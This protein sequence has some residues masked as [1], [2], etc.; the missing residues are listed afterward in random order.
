MSEGSPTPISHGVE[1]RKVKIEEIQR[2]A[3]DRYKALT[4]LSKVVEAQIDVELSKLPGQKNLTELAGL[5]EKK[6]ALDE[7]GDELEEMI[8]RTFDQQDDLQKR[9]ATIE[10]RLHAQGIV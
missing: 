10:R 7:I 2:F 1:I 4:A 8:L 5:F 6:H 3:M 9:L